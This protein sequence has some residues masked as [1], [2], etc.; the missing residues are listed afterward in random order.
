MMVTTAARLHDLEFHDRC[1][2]LVSGLRCMLC[3]LVQDI[4]DVPEAASITCVRC[5]RQLRY[6][7]AEH[8]FVADYSSTPD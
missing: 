4:G 1:V 7:V 5:E 8:D 6:G 2:V 3:D